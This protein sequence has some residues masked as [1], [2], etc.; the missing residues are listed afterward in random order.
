[1]KKPRIFP[2]PVSSNVA[3][4]SDILAKAKQEGLKPAATTPEIDDNEH[5]NR[6]RQLERQVDARQPT[7]VDVVEDGDGRVWLELS[8]RVKYI[9]FSPEIA[10]ALANELFQAARRAAA[11]K[12]ANAA[13]AKMDA[14]TTPAPSTP[15]IPGNVPTKLH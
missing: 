15:P 8:R 7:D 5:A 2:L 9:P 11:R 13:L 6:V 14:A 10:I 3:R 1:M 12:Q 4:A